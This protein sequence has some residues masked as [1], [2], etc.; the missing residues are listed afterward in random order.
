MKRQLDEAQIRVQEGA[1][2]TSE[3]VAALEEPSAPLERIIANR[4][5]AGERRQS[6]NYSCTRPSQLHEVGRWNGAVQAPIHGSPL[7]N[8]DL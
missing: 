7:A 6:P 4:L 1:A 5:N 3:R 8:G 2:T